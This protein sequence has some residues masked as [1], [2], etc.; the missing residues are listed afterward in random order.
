MLLFLVFAALWLPA[1]LGLFVRCLS[2][3]FHYPTPKQASTNINGTIF[4]LIMIIFEFDSVWKG[5][6]S[7]V[8]DFEYPISVTDPDP[9]PNVKKLYL[10]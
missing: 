2:G 10:L 5:F 9:Y 7:S 4:F 8:S 1:G 6:Y 3:L